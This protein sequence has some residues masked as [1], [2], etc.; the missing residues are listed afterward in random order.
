MR[1]E[2]AHLLEWARF[3]LAGGAC[4]IILSDDGSRDGGPAALKAALGERVTVIPWRLSGSD[5][6]TAGP[7]HPQILAH[8][9]ALLSFGGSFARMT[10]L[11]VDEFLVPVTA[12][13]IEAALAATGDHSNVSLPWVQFG[14]CGREAPPAED[15][16]G[17]FRER[18][19]DMAKD[20]NFKLVLDPCEVTSLSVHHARTRSRGA[21]TVNDR[22]EAADYAGRKASR[23]LS[24]THLQLNHYFTR[25]RAEFEAKLLRGSAATRQRSVLATT[26][27]HPERRPWASRPTRCAATG[28]RPSRGGRVSGALVL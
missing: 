21:E 28:R 11:A 2:G 8:V 14:C 5:A 27:G 4:P 26:P 10:V 3:H 19:R 23:F 22:G 20:L 12:P 25:S 1:D 6:A 18:A 15:T 24:A 13:G 7:L 16:V 17:G 9:H